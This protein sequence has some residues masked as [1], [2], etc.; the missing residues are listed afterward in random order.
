MGIL[1]FERREQFIRIAV[2][3]LIDE[4]KRLTRRITIS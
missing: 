1:G 2:K 3:R 4:Y